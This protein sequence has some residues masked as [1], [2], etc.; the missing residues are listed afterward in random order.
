[1]MELSS[2]SKLPPSSAQPAAAETPEA[3]GASQPTAGGTPV[4]VRQAPLVRVSP[5]ARIVHGAPPMEDT[6]ES[7]EYVPP[8]Y[9]TPEWVDMAE[10]Q[11]KSRREAEFG[12]RQRLARLLIHTQGLVGLL[13]LF[14]NQ[15]GGKLSD[16]VGGLG[17]KRSFS[18]QGMRMCWRWH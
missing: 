6:E 14:V 11:G 17:I 15:F 3:W 1:M 16:A 4:H 2:S 7:W 8:K 5:Q 9:G 18:L 12:R 13:A 10:L